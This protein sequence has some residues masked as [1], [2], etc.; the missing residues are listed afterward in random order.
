[1][2]EPDAVRNTTEDAR[3]MAGMLEATGNP[4]TAAMLRR[5]AGEIDR[6]RRFVQYVADHSNDP[7]IVKEAM[8]HGGK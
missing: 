3:L 7:Q 5:Q 8:A 6:L 1:M 4:K 2:H